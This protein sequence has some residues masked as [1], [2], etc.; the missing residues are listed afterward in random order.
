[1]WISAVFKDE[2]TLREGREK[3]SGEGK[4]NHQAGTRTNKLE[5]DEKITKIQSTLFF[6]C[7]LD[8]TT[9]ST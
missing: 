8:L 5:A 4:K 9:S 7:S 3:E 1:M 2:V 6:I